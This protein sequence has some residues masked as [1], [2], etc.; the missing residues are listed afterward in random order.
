[1]SRRTLQTDHFARDCPHWET[2]PAWHREHLNSKGAGPQKKA[3]M[4]CTSSLFADGP[5]MHWVGS[6]TLVSL[7]VEGHE[8]NALADS[9]SQV[10]TVMP[11][12]VCQHKFPVLPLEDLVDHPLNLVGLGGMRTQ[13]LGF[14]I[15]QVKVTEITGYDEDVVFLVVPDEYEFSRCVPILIG[16]CML[17]RI[18]NV[19]KESELD[20][21]STLWVMARAS[22]LL[23]RQGTAVVDL[24]AAGDGLMEEGATTPES[25]QSSEIDKL[26][27]MKENMRLGLFQTQILKCKTSPT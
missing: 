9:G 5:T 7:K 13:P 23:S 19:I 24:G 27:F 25:S 22:H 18:V 20:R 14:V 1:M 17:K 3:P 11:G 15:L 21:L 26:V 8:I 10:N 12:Y 2:F 6:E 4:C 16:T